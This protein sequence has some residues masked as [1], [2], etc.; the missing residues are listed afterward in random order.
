MKVVAA[1]VNDWQLS[2]VISA[3]SGAR[4]TPT[5][6]YNSNGSSVNL[7]GSPSYPA[8]IVLTRAIPGS[9]CSDNRY[10]QFNVSAFSGPAVGS[11]GMES[12]LNFLGGCADHTVDLAIQR[13]FRLGG[14]RRFMIR[15]DV[16]NAFNAVVCNGRQTQLQ[17]NSPSDLTV[18]NPQYVVNAGDTTLA[19][20][21]TPHDA[22]LEPLAHEQRRLRGRDRRAG[23]AEPAAQR[24]L[25]VLA[26]SSDTQ[27]GNGRPDPPVPVFSYRQFLLPPVSHF[28][29]LATWRESSMTSTS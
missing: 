2:G 14:N 13:T 8:R 22:E 9:G 1:V 24:A 21:A 19:P 17:L 20:G 3:G 10:A 12:G 5:F 6:S 27:T 29:T 28:T 7:T 18:R 11:L 16:F 15:L 23:D 26:D 4:Y 25:L